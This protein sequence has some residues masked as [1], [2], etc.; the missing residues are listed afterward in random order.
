MKTLL[1][2]LALVAPL[3]ADEAPPAK[4]SLCF[5]A[6]KQKPSCTATEGTT[7]KVAPAEADRQFVWSSSDGKTIAAGILAAKGDQINV[8]DLT[9]RDVTLTLHGD[10]AHGWPS[11]VRLKIADANKHEWLWAIS[12]KSV[13]ALA[14][15]RLPPGRYSINFSAEH[16][17]TELRRVDVAKSVSLREVT[18]R[19]MPAA[20]GRVLSTEDKPVSG[21]LIVRAD[22]KV[23]AT[24]DEQ[25]ASAVS[26]DR[27]R[28][29]FKE[30]GTRFSLI[31]FNS[32]SATPT[33]RRGKPRN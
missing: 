10:R 16:H 18:L 9:L 6:A 28:L 23:I 8:A 2:S 26:G 32:P 11:E 30:N 24:S 19:P 22:R 7:F 29:V 21:A 17:L 20:Y 3:L 14:Q 25:G 5:L 31:H 15:L 13:E 12:G 4:G 33:P 1:L 27:P